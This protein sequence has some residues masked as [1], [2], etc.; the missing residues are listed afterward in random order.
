MLIGWAG[1]R[2]LAPAQ[3]AESNTA[4][5]E[6]LV[7]DEWRVLPNQAATMPSYPLY[8]S[9]RYR[10]DGASVSRESREPPLALGRL[11]VRGMGLPLRRCDE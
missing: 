5:V 11:P 9:R 6:I 2:G 7:E 4:E 10:L 1:G 3:I 8:L